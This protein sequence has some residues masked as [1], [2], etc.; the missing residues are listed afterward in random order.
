M[1]D[2]RGLLTFYR[3]VNRTWIPVA[4]HH[5]GLGRWEASEILVHVSDGPV[6]ARYQLHGFVV[7]VEPGPPPPEVPIQKP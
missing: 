7:V 6:P 4:F 2:P 5:L 1:S 3:S